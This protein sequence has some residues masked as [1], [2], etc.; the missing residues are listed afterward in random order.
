MKTHNKDKYFSENLIL[1]FKKNKRNLPWRKSVSHKDYPYRVLVSEFMLQQTT[2]STVIPYFNKFLKIWPNIKTLSKAKIDDVLIQWQ[3][4]GYYSRA[5]NLLKTA[6][7]IMLKHQGDIPR[8]ENELKSLPGIGEYASAAI[9]S[10]AFNK[11]ASAVDGNVKRV[12]ARFYGLTGTLDENKKRID[13]IANRICPNKNNRDYTQAIMEIGALVCKAKKINCDVCCI[14]QKC[15]AYNKKLVHSI[16]EPKVKVKKRK[17][18]CISF[19]SI[20]NDRFVLLKKRSSEGIL[21]NQWELPSTA[22]KAKSIKFSRKETPFPNAHWEKTAINFKHSF[23]HMDIQ[24][25]AYYARNNN[26]CLS[27]SSSNLKWVNVDKLSDYAVTT[28]S[29]KT[30]KKFNLIPI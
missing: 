29:K 6:E 21:S 16:P 9:R 28:M 20:F 14:S 12:I 11:K 25:I 1:W 3:G 2:V 23:S 4:L 24:N 15:T 17:L 30:L 26:K 19:I 5:R 18:N 13:E 8:S 7:I 10:I 27:S 22:W